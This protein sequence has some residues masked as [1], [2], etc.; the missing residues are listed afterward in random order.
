MR[1]FF[2]ASS[3]FASKVRMAARVC[4]LPL[5]LVATDTNTEPDDLLA[6]NPLG[7][8]PALA[9]DNG[10]VLYDSSVICEY[11]DR[12][13]G[14]PL[15][16]QT[17]DA[18]LQAK[19]TEALADGVAEAGIAVI[20]EKRHRPENKW[21]EPWIDKQWRRAGRGLDRLEAEV[22]SMPASVGLG[23]V[24][25]AATLGWLE[26]RFAGQWQE[27]RPALTAWLDRFPEVFPPFAE[28]RPKG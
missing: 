12:L 18:W 13:S 20:Y 7:K 6:T 25:L 10:E 3:P 17:T 26:L 1:L 22:G 9:L 14:N 2:S 5:D 19:R 15:I 11:L 28:M 21:H 24:A 27:N 16:P 23:A 4:D 8:I